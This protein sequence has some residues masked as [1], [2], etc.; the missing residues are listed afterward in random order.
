MYINASEEGPRPA[1]P[2][3]SCYMSNADFSVKCVWLPNIFHYDLVTNTKL[4]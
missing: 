3:A 2:K 4:V 1:K